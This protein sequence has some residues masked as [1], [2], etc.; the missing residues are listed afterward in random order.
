M[1]VSLK[2]KIRFQT[3]TAVCQDHTLLQYDTVYLLHIR[4]RQREHRF[5]VFQRLL[6][7]QV[8]RRTSVDGDK[9]RQI[10]F[11]D[12]AFP[13]IAVQHD[14]Q[15]T[16]AARHGF[17]T[18]NQTFAV[19]IHSVEKYKRVCL[20]Q[21]F[22]YPVLR[23]DRHSFR[24]SH[25]LR[26]HDPVKSKSVCIVAF[27]NQPWRKRIASRAR[28][29]HAVYRDP[30]RIT[31]WRKRCRIKIRVVKIHIKIRVHTDFGDTDRRKLLLLFLIPASRRYKRLRTRKKFHLPVFRTDRHAFFKFYFPGIHDP[32][33]SKPV[34]VI[35]FRNHS[36]RECVAACTRHRRIV[37]FDPVCKRTGS[38]RR[39]RKTS[40][41]EIDIKIRVHTDFG[42][43]HRL[44]L[45]EYFRIYPAERSDKHLIF[46]QR[47]R[48]AV[49][50]TD[51]HA[52]LEY[53]FRRIGDSIERKSVRIVAIRNVARFER[54]AACSLCR[55]T[56]HKDPLRITSHS[57]RRF[58]KARFRKI[59]V[60]IRVDP[61]FAHSHTRSRLPFLR[62][63]HH[64]K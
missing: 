53:N 5:A 49:F 32:V 46:L 36:R 30:G 18:R 52:R 33:K 21:I 63:H 12:R 28:R 50:R 48:T 39:R 64:P 25:F 11:V 35:A 27:R 10:S 41:A 20:F 54:V 7:Q 57:D 60:K 38:Y 3:G 37:R 61:H 9:S 56:V 42:H 58:R 13:I 40:F 24:K 34:R 26:I 22:R 47:H 2:Y 45:F 16:F 1:R 43:F 62:K 44:L 31:A 15:L 59:Y 19:Y 29:S 51:R 8:L 55:Y 6:S 23:A 4:I 14:L 17:D